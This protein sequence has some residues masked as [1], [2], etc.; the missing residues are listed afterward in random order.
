MGNPILEIRLISTSTDFFM[1]NSEQQVLLCSPQN[2]EIVI[3]IIIRLL[4]VSDLVLVVIST[5]LIRCPTEWLTFLR[6]YI[7]MYFLNPKYEHCGLNRSGVCSQGPSCQLLQL[8]L[9]QWWPVD[10]RVQCMCGQ[11]T[12]VHIRVLDANFCRMPWCGDA[13]I[14][15]KSLTSKWTPVAENNSLSVLR[16]TAHSELAHNIR[17]IG[18][19]LATLY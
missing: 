4:V 6:R 11:A 5:G 13:W 7:Q 10:W 1:N 2:R 16:L 12:W 18:A 17:F 8:L 3:I 14:S 9:S 15:T 19:F